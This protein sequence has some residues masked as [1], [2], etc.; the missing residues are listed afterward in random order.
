MGISLDG[1]GSVAPV[2]DTDNGRL[3]AD[4]TLDKAVGP[5]QFLPSTWATW[6]ADGDGDGIRD[7][8]D[9]DDA[10]LGAGRYLCVAGDLATADGWTRAILSYNHSIDYL[11]A[12]YD[13]AQTFAQ[14]SAAG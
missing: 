8:Q 13:A 6:A 11:D 9:I 14:R 5:L 2:A 4:P 12:V 1:S 7:P 3:D 10:A